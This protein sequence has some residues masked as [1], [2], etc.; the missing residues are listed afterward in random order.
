MVQNQQF[1]IILAEKT[2]RSA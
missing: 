1:N 2:S